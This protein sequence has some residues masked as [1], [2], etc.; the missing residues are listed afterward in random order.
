MTLLIKQAKMFLFQYLLAHQKSKKIKLTYKA[1]LLHI[2]NLRVCC[3]LFMVLVKKS[4]QYL[5]VVK[6]SF[7]RKKQD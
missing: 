3:L 6:K 7:Q 4:E 1:E 2:Q 5:K